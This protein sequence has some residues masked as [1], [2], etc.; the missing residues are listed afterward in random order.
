MAAKRS[1]ADVLDAALRVREAA[2]HAVAGA[3]APD[4]VLTAL[5]DVIDYDHASLSRW[6]PL[7]RRHLTLA[8]S[9][10]ADT[11]AYIETRLHDDPVF[12][13]IRHSTGGTRWLRDVPGQ[14]RRT[15]PGFREVL[16]PRGIE[17]GVAQC[18][19][20]PDGRYVGVLN[21]STTR[22]RARQDPARGVLTLLGECLAA[23]ADPLWQ[24]PSDA[25]GTPDGTADQAYAVALPAAER[26]APVPLAGAAP[27]PE[28]ADAESPLTVLVR[29]MAARRALPATVLVPHG[30]RLLELRLSRQ[31]A[32]TVV[33]CRPV[34]RPAGLSPREL[35]VLAE[36]THGRTNREIAARLFVG[37]RTVATHIEHILAKLDVANRAAAAARAAAWGLEPVD[38]TGPAA[39]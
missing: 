31:G 11:A 30:R 37:T 9:Y 6:D 12:A 39:G 1:T 29:R 17:D 3:A 32:G 20:A 4:S 19:F 36:L 21:V 35:E 27:P 22:V 23:V 10:P 26:A 34:A 33:V 15:S 18:L 38:G 28:F 7:R 2:R 25:P 13:L 14:L 8:G 24:P 5:S 16:E